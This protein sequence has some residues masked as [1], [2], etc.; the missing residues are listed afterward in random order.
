MEEQ[1]H[2]TGY[3]LVTKGIKMSWSSRG[4]GNRL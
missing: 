1:R 2:S 3:R 4:I